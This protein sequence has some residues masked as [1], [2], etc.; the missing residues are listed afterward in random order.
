MQDVVERLRASKRKADDEGYKVGHAAGASWA[1]SEAEA[2]ELERLDEHG[3]TFKGYIGV[4]SS[5]YS[6]AEQ[7]A[8]II[9]GDPEFENFDRHEA[10]S[11]WEMVGEEAP[12]ESYLAGF[13]DGALEVWGE[14]KARL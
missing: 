6:P 13:I 5:A 1:K 10:A 2:V 4:G 3:E 7:L 14:V 9:A 11:F 12:G 8:G